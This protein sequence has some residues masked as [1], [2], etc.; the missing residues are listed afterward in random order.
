MKMI[1]IINVIELYNN[2]F[3][4]ISKDYRMKLLFYSKKGMYI[5]SCMYPFFFFFFFFFLLNIYKF[6]N[7]IK[8]K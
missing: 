4:T 8:N 5:C 6:I 3:L 1:V 2:L 7:I